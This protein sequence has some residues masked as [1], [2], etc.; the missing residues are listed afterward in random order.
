MILVTDAKLQL[1][2]LDI[3]QQLHEENALETNANASVETAAP[4]R[5]TPMIKALVFRGPNEIALEERP[6]PK[7]GIGQAVI[8]VT[9]T[10]ICG[11]D[12]HILKGALPSARPPMV[13]GHEIAGVIADIENNVTSVRI[14]ERITVDAV[15]GCGICDLRGLGRIQF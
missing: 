14:G 7:A 1:N 3:K 15:I 9:M 13:L 4:G 2:D 6:I 5:R 10:T 11:T 8:R 12:I